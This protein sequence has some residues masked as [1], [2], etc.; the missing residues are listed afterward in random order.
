MAPLDPYL[1]APTGVAVP[2]NGCDHHLA[3]EPLALQ[4]CRRKQSLSSPPNG[5]HVQ[6]ERCRSR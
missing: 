6:L 1:A 5:E 4:N 3:A 2:T